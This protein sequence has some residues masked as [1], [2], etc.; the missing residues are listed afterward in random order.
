MKFANT[1]NQIIVVS[2]KLLKAT[3][4]LTSLQWNIIIFN[5]SKYT[6]TYSEKSRRDFLKRASIGT[7][8]LV[9]ENFLKSGV[10]DF[11]VHH[12]L[13][14]KLPWYKRAARWDR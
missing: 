8:M 13:D 9:T 12:R 11:P 1:V 10:K 3:P 7:A 4:A 14:D 2:D 5:S 6:M